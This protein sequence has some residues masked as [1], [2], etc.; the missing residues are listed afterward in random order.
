VGGLA[1]SLHVGGKNQIDANKSADRDE[2]AAPIRAIRARAGSSWWYASCLSTSIVNKPVSWL[3]VVLAIAGGVWLYFGRTVREPGPT[4]TTVTVTRGDIVETVDATGTLQAVTTVQVGTQVSGTIK[5]LH[6]DFNSVVRRGQVIAELE[7]SL[8]ETQVEQ[9]RASLARLEAEVRRAEVQLEDARQ[10]LRRARELADRALV[11]ASELDA[12]EANA[13]M[14]DAAL[15]GAQ[16]QVAQARAALHQSEVNLDHTIITAPIDGI[17]VSRNVAVGQTVAASMQA[18]T[19]FVIARDLRDMQVE[20]SV[21]ESDI[22]RVQTGQRVTFHVD[23]Y[24]ADVFEG[25]VSQ[26]RLQPTVEQNVVSYVTVIDVPNRDLR[27]KPGMT[28][29]VTVEIAR[30]TDV[31]VV[32]NS[33]LRVRPGAA[34]LLAVGQPDGEAGEAV[35]TSGAQGPRHAG[36]ADDEIWTFAAGTLWPLRV[37]VGISDGTRTAVSSPELAEGLTVVTAISED[38]A[39]VPATGTSPLLPSFRGRGGGVGRTPGAPAPDR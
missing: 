27:L 28:A 29:T 16:A 3:V 10:K 7:P 25:T 35:P 8:F 6:A 5:S 15:G 9:A 14:A 19:L 24:P 18:P 34:T 31:F 1:A 13:R 33:A 23:A 2:S 30:A 26:V 11:A 39:A 12:A 17:V 20:A 38:D 37:R 36:D 21:A 22:G 4:I 32:P